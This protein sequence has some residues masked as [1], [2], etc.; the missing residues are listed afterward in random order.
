MLYELLV[1]RK[2]TNPNDTSVINGSNK[3]HVATRDKLEKFEQIMPQ[4]QDFTRL[5]VL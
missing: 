4:V 5:D 3:I 2:A 1:R